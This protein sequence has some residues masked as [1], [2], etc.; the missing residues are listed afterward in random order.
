MNNEFKNKSL[1]HHFIYIWNMTF[2][3]GRINLPFFVSRLGGTLNID[4][5]LLNI[6]MNIPLQ[7]CLI[8]TLEF[9]C[10]QSFSYKFLYLLIRLVLKQKIGR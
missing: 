4:C 2:G 8:I 7:I 5:D 1:C 9:L 6:I 10:K 3:I